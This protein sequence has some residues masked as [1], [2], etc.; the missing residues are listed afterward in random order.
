MEEVVANEAVALVRVEV[1]EVALLA[2]VAEDMLAHQGR[3]TEE[4]TDIAVVLLAVAAVRLLLE[5]LHLLSPVAT[6]AQVGH[7]QSLV[8]L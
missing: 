4:E 2:Q 6:V 7:R 3:V 8:L 5:E 1:L